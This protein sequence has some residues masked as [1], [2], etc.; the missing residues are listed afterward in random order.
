[1]KPIVVKPNIYI[2]FNEEN[3]EEGTKVKV[4]D[5]VRIS[6][7]KNIFAKGYVPNWSD[8]VFVIKESKNAVPW[9]YVISDIEAKETEKLR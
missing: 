3:N 7:F 2:D 5:N 1:M 8:E 9:T 6:K 4:G